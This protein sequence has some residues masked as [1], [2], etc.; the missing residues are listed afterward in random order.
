MP[1]NRVFIS[2]SH[3]AEDQALLKEFRVHLKPWEKTTLL[4]MWS[5][6]QIKP[7]QDWHR[8]IQDALE[9]T[10][11]AILLVSPEFLASDYIRRYELP[12][13]LRAC[14][15]GYVKLACLYLRHSTVAHDDAAIEVELSSGETKR[16]K[17]TQYQGFNDPAVVVASLRERNQRDAVYAKAASDLKELVAPPSPPRSLTGKRYEL[18]VQFKRNGNQLT[19]IYWHQYSRFAEYRSPWQGTGQALLDILFGSQE[20]CDKVL[21]ALFDSKELARPIRHPVRVRLHTDDPELADLPWTETTWEGNSLCEHGW[22]FELINDKTL[23]NLPNTAPGSPVIELKA[24][25]PVLMI[26]PSAASDAEGHHRA[27]EERLKQAWPFY[28]EPPLLVR[29]WAALEQAWQRRKPRIVYYY[30]PAESDGKTLTLLLD[31]AQGIDRRPVT[32]LAQLWQ[33]DPPQIVFCNLVGEPVSPGV[34]L[35]GLTV[36]LAI[37]QNGSDPTEARRAVLE[38]LHAFVRG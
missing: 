23:H 6:Q 8:E 36:P 27:V 34:A 37:T 33:A 2:Y 7:S 17:L 21:R 38:W 32:A 24:P 5:D 18:T 30:G 12:S 26:A 13:L 10:A 19:R 20:Q 28:H 4:D 22:T 25:C 15:E 1:R 11:V 9:S 3:N 35:S 16:L 31:G 14:E 29:D